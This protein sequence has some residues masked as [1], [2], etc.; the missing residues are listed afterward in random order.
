MTKR[1]PGK[2][3]SDYG[4]QDYYKYYNTGV[5]PKEELKKYFNKDIKVS[6]QLYCKILRDYF[7]IISTRILD[8]EY[9]EI[10][11]LG[12]LVIKKRKLNFAPKNGRYRLPMN[13]RG[14]LVTGIKSF[15]LNDHS[16]NFIFK[17][18]WLKSKLLKHGRYYYFTASRQLNRDLAVRIFAK[19]DYPE[20]R[21][22]TIDKNVPL[23]SNS[24]TND[25]S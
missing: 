3:N 16:D 17:V 14:Y 11:K 9:V 25:Y 1:G 6:K 13:F 10:P 5:L 24:P 21:F 19:Q 12:T 23:D 4:L 20:V 7:K 18:Y 8:G 22:S 2:K 15:L